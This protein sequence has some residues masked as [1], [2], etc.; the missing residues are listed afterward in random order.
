VIDILR[1]QAS[2]E[3]LSLGDH[4]WACVSLVVSEFA[5]GNWA[6]SGLTSF[7]DHESSPLHS[8]LRRWEMKAQANSDRPTGVRS[9][10]TRDSDERA[11]QRGKVA[12]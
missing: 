9:K 1:Q 7:D 4:Y 10:V 12:H 5:G 3:G 6:S 2:A 11:G 8:C